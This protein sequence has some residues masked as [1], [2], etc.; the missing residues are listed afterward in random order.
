MSKKT[1]HKQWLKAKKFI[2][3][4]NKN[5]SDDVFSGRFKVSLTGKK[6]DY[7]LANY[8][9][10]TPELLTAD[11]AGDPAWKYSVYEVRIEDTEEPERSFNVWCEYS[12]NFGMIDCHIEDENYYSIGSKYLQNCSGLKELW[13]VVNNFII[14]SDFW[15][16]WK[17]IEYQKTHWYSGKC[18]DDMIAYGGSLYK[19][20]EGAK[21]AREL[22]DK[23]RS[24]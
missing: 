15:D 7:Y 14:Y 4:I 3:M 5:L 11:N 10:Y 20:P 2:K 21:L 17:D 19:T 9:C 13:W 22:R 6:R 12:N 24:K 23:E 8:L 16:K 18:L 1:I